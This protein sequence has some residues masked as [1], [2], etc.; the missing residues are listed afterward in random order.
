MKKMKI[1]TVK[2]EPL[3]KSKQN[4]LKGGFASASSLLQIKNKDK[5]MCLNYN[6][7]CGPNPTNAC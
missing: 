3:K 6:C 5:N 4:L 2:I 7:P 1:I